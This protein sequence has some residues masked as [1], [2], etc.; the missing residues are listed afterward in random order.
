MKLVLPILALIKAVTRKNAI[1]GNRGICILFLK[2]VK[3]TKNRESKKATKLVLTPRPS[4]SKKPL[5]PNKIAI[6]IDDKVKIFFILIN[7]LF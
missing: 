1:I 2:R 7:Y 3:K 4:I 5:K 6:N